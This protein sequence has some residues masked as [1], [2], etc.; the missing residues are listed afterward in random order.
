MIS[1]VMS[2]GMV[3]LMLVGIGAAMTEYPD[4]AGAIQ[5]KQPIPVIASNNTT[6]IQ[7][8]AFDA[9]GLP[10]LETMNRLTAASGVKPLYNQTQ[11]QQRQEQYAKAGRA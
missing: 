3:V 11:M 2:L 5:N 7:T 9:N 1:R 6:E 10:T 8:G 4:F